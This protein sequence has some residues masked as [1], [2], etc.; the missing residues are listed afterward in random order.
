MYA[1]SSELSLV[2]GST[3]EMLE[4]ASTLNLTF[5]QAEK[6]LSNIMGDVHIAKWLLKQ[7]Q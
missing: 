7:V 3:S 1:F 2:K 4:K 6:G 5:E